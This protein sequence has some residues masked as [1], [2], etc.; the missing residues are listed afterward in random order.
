[1][2]WNNFNIPPTV[3]EVD[4][5]ERL[6]QQDGGSS[7]VGGEES[8]EAS[9]DT[10]RALHDSKLEPLMISMLEQRDRLQEQLV[11]MQKRI[12]DA[13]ERCRDAI[14]ERD[15]LRRQLE[16]TRQDLP[17]EVQTLTRELAHCREQLYEKEEEIVEL[18]AERNNTRLL[19]E[20]LECLVSKHEKS[21]RFT[22]VKRHSQI[23]RDNSVSSEVEV[24][25][26]LKSLFEHHKALEEKVRERLKVAIERVQSLEV[27]LNGKVEE[28]ATLKSKLSKALAE[29][30][31]NINENENNIAEGD[32]KHINSSTK[33]TSPKLFE[34][35][36][37]LDRINAELESELS[38]AGK[39]I[40]Q[41]KEQANSAE[42]QLQ[43]LQAQ[44]DEQEDRVNLL[45]NRILTAQRESACLRELNDKLEFQLA[46]KD[47]TMRLNEEKLHSLHERFELAEKQLAQSLKKAESLPSVEAELLQRMEALTAAEQKH[48]S[49]EERIQRLEVLLNERSAELDRAVQRERMNEEHN[50]RLS[51][52]VDKLLS[53]SNERLQVHLKERMQA[54]I[55]RNIL[56]QQLDQ[57]KKLFD[58][59]ERFKERATAENEDLRKEIEMLRNLVYSTRTAQFYSR[60]NGFPCPPT[61][62]I[63]NE[64]EPQPY[65]LP[66]PRQNAMSTS[67]PT[68]TPGM[69]KRRLQK[70][71]VGALQEDPG[72]IQTLGE[73]EWDRLQQ[74]SVLA[75]IQQAF[76]SSSSLLNMNNS[77]SLE[78]Q[79]PP[80]P[81]T[82]AYVLQERLDAINNEIRLI[83]EQK[84]QTER[85]AAEQMEQQ[86]TS[87]PPNLPNQVADTQSAAQ[88]S[89]NPYDMASY[90]ARVRDSQLNFNEQQ[91]MQQ[92]YHGTDEHVPDPNWIRNGADQVHHQRRFSPRRGARPDTDR[93]RQQLQDRISPVSSVGS[94]P[95]LGVP[96]SSAQ[97]NATGSKPPKKS[98]STSSGLKTLGRIFG[99]SQRK[100][101]GTDASSYSDSECGPSIT[102]GSV[103]NLNKMGHQ[104]L[105]NGGSTLPITKMASS[106]YGLPPADF[107][108]RKRRKHELLE[109]AIKARTPFALWNGPTIVA[110][111]E[112]WVGMPTWYTEACRANVK[113]GAIMSAL[114]DQEI[115]REI[116]VS[117]PLH[118]LKL[119][120]AIQEMVAL[121]SPSSPRTQQ[122]YSGLAFGEMNHEWIGNEWLP[123]LGLGRYRVDFMEC[124]VD[125]RM[126]E[127]LSKRDLNKSLKIVDSFHRLI[128]SFEQ[129]SFICFRTSLHYGIVCLKKLNYERKQLEERRQ[130]CENA[131]KDLLVWSNERVS[132]WLEEIGLGMFIANLADSGVHG[133]LMALDETFDVPALA[134][135]LQIGDNDQALRVLDTQFGK[136]VSEY[137]IPT[138]GKIGKQQQKGRDKEQQVTKS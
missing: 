91:M 101:R 40:R 87:W 46:N 20:H 8:D 41:A 16:T 106:S 34:L 80:D 30:K 1:M 117:N 94:S 18:K 133:A 17:S 28:N 12:E 74:A 109:E 107:D 81:H 23:N 86:K 120:L 3:S 44:R 99:G 53:E 130:I 54:Q 4:V 79:Q 22:V 131:N 118:R 96:G 55:E 83:Q 119:R 42:Q 135:I 78:Q 7:L 77:P 26:A 47:A 124:L 116:G 129:L 48:L 137:R 14:R 125:A 57:A 67:M 5:D 33:G 71:R 108:K 93:Q 15:S 122:F 2:S 61:L 111:L 82:L 136:L 45:E 37:Q 43:E 127:H 59:A 88:F 21:L 13:D 52:T 39:E 92:R 121:T 69:V 36:E 63:G 49:A 123:S 56:M 51:S 103:D 32:G 29:A 65:I 10:I 9:S 60:L 115:Q 90:L 76:S 100:K 62:P 102:G 35:Q 112:L 58:Q 85:I 134:H 70:G 113:S 104:K 128:Y 38:N 105:L 132:K 75:N 72:K 11:R 50:Q 68:A 19:L 126:L 31:K 110:W 64:M 25:K 84:Q 95:D 66:P 98:T 27:E 6:Q 24:L 114:S 73:K 89:N 138:S 97:I